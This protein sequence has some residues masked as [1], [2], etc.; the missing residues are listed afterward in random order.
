TDQDKV[1][2]TFFKRFQG[3]NANCIVDAVINVDG[4]CTEFRLI[5]VRCE[6]SNISRVDGWKSQFCRCAL[7]G[8]VCF[9]RNQENGLPSNYRTCIQFPIETNVKSAGCGKSRQAVQ[10]AFDRL[11]TGS[12]RGKVVVS[13]LGRA[14]QQQEVKMRRYAELRRKRVWVRYRAHKTVVDGRISDMIIRIRIIPGGTTVKTARQPKGTSHGKAYYSLLEHGWNLFLLL[15]RY[16]RR[17]RNRSAPEF[18]S[19]ACSACCL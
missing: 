14:K 8:G 12:G 15:C 19:F 2:A 9:K 10:R 1:L 13:V 4:F 11:R 18:R 5:R 16:I 6:S 3:G 17:R 7:E